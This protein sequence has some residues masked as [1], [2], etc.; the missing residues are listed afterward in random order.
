VRDA[1]A[2]DA[3]GF[4]T[5]RRLLHLLE[6][7][8]LVPGTAAPDDELLA[9]GRAMQDGRGGVVQ[10]TSDFFSADHEFA[11]MTRLARETGNPV[12]L[13]LPQNPMTRRHGGRSWSCPAACSRAVRALGAKRT[14][15][16]IIS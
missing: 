11:W 8:T 3:I 12:V 5:S 9:I 14:A 10:L 1:I 4:S 7:R 13:V 6:R 15:G 2:V 16:I